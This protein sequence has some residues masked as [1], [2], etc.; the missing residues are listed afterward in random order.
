[1]SDDG[2]ILTITE[3]RKQRKRETRRSIFIDGEF[4]FG[5]SEEAYVKF[6][7]FRGREITHAFLD[8]VRTWEERYQAK[9]VALRMVNGRM[10]SRSEIVSKL[11]DREFD[12]EVIE[13]TLDFLREYDLTD[14]TAFAKAWINDQLLK[15]PLGRSRLVQGLREKGVPEEAVTEALNERFDHEKEFDEALRAAEKKAPK[16]RKTDPAVWDRSMSNFLAGRGFS[17]SI[18]REILARYRDERNGS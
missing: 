3:V 1:M 12:Q 13:Y 2:R 15:R 17:W 7:L 14:D 11:K 5:V 8:E 10:R 16:I 6:A 9:Q 18:V 4:A